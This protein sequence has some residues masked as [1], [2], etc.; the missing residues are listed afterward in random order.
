[1]ST[2]LLPIN[3]K[4]IQALEKKKGKEQACFF[5]WSYNDQRAELKTFYKPIVFFV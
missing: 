4:F 5:S 3:F 1:M 2:N